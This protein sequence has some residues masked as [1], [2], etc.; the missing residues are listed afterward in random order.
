MHANMKRMSKKLKIH[1]GI[2]YSTSVKFGWLVDKSWLQG[3]KSWLQGFPCRDDTASKRS[4]I[5]RFPRLSRVPPTAIVGGCC[6]FGCSWTSPS[7]IHLPIL[8]TYYS[9]FHLTVW[10]CTFE[11]VVNV[12]AANVTAAFNM[13]KPYLDKI[14]TLNHSQ[15]LNADPGHTNIIL[16]IRYH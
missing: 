7:Y 14:W 13:A 12:T 3:F 10:V 5:F 1:L 2:E 11:I 8:K 4:S 16:L 6:G 15:E 9:L